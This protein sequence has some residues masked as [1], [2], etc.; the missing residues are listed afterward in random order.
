[1]DE[2]P[3]FRR[4]VM[5]PEAFRAQMD[6]LAHAGY[7]TLTVSKVA[8]LLAGDSPLPTRTVALT[9]DDGFRDFHEAA[10]PVLQE[11]GFSATIYVPTSYVGATKGGRPVLS[12]TLLREIAEGGFE[13]GAHGHLH[14]RLDQSDYGAALEEARRSRMLLE[15][16]LQK[17]ILSFA[18][19]GGFWNSRAKRAVGAAGFHSA[20]VVGELV[21]S[22]IDDPL[23][24]PRLTVRAW[25][26]VPGLARLLARRPTRAARA[27]SVGRRWLARAPLLLRLRQ[28]G[29]RHGLWR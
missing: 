23:A 21:A 27:A 6:Y 18:Y 2:D 12:W 14:R 19:P 24:L 20:C 22:P 29:R 26:D 28:V 25:V 7:C 9:F 5:R 17:S 1:V 13:C 15:D 8:L 10:L 11:H 16:R 4:F 3:S